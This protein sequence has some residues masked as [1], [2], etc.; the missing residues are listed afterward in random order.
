[1][2]WGCP[3]ESIYHTFPCWN[4]TNIVFVDHKPAQ[5]SCNP[6]A[7][8]IIATLFYISQLTKVGDDKQFLKMSLW[9]KLNALFKSAD[10][11]NFERRCKNPRYK[12][13]KPEDFERHDNER[14]SGDV[15]SRQGDGTCEPL[16]STRPLSPHLPQNF[17]SDC[18]V[19]VFHVQ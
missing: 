19:N 6:E 3:L 12:K 5:V 16:D 2:A 14:R 18:I 11:A 4:S 1:M 7:N 10:L 13:R 8:T 17:V 15:H 9:P